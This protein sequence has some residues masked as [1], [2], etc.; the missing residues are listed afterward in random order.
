MS[1]CGQ[2]AAAG[3]VMNADASGSTGSTTPF[4]AVGWMKFWMYPADV[5]HG[6]A[7]RVGVIV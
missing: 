7:P 6:A 4:G 2:A 3:V 1:A 5:L